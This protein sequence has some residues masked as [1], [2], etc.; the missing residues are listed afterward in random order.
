MDTRVWNSG[1]LGQEGL[2]SRANIPVHCIQ[3]C[4]GKVLVY[5]SVDVGRDQVGPEK[6]EFLTWFESRPK[7]FSQQRLIQMW[8][9]FG[10][11]I[12][13]YFNSKLF[14]ALHVLQVGVATCYQILTTHNYRLGVVE[15]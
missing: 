6:V 10:C 3:S 1:Y 8:I 2:H 11:A 14:E 12:G 4:T 15:S 9:G 13:V 7:Q 5:K